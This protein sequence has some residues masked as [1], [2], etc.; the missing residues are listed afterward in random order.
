[1]K[2]ELVDIKEKKDSQIL[3][4]IN[5]SP[6]QRFERMFD[7]IEFCIAFSKTP[8]MPT[9]KVGWTTVILKKKIA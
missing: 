1:M 6:S 8:K 3:E 7:W 2:I 9:D 4:D 5:L